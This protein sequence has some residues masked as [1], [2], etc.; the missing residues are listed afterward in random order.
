M[1]RQKRSSVDWRD[2]R[3]VRLHKEALTRCRVAAAMT[4]TALHDVFTAAV[5]ELVPE[6]SG[7]VEAYSELGQALD[8]LREYMGEEGSNGE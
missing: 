1:V 7:D 8:A 2:T 5:F 4:D 6:P 3:V